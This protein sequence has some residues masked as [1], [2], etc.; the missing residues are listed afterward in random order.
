MRYPSRSWVA[1]LPLC[2]LEKSLVRDDRGERNND[3]EEDL[4]YRN[5]WYREDIEH[6]FTIKVPIV[7]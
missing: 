2:E 3:K 5:F 7:L 6:L 1:A 4:F